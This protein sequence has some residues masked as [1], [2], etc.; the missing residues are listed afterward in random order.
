[1]KPFMD[2]Y[3]DKLCFDLQKFF[4]FEGADE[5]SENGLAYLNVHLKSNFSIELPPDFSRRLKFRNQK[6]ITRIHQHLYK[7]HGI[8]I[9][10]EFKTKLGNIVS[11]NAVKIP[12]V[13]GFTRDI[14]WDAGA[15]ADSGSCF[16]SDRWGTKN[17]IRDTGFAMLFYDQQDFDIAE[18][19]EA[20]IKKGLNY[21]QYRQSVPPKIGSGRAW[22]LPYRLAD[23]EEELG[24]AV[25]NAYH[26]N[27]N[28]THRYA[29]MVLAQH[30][31]LD[32]R[33]FRTV[34]NN[35]AYD[36]LYI[37]SE[38]STLVAPTENFAKVPN[39]PTQN[40][41]GIDFKYDLGDY[42]E[43]E[44]SYCECCNER[45]RLDDMT[46]IEGWGDVCEYCRDSDFFHCE[47]CCEYHHNDD[48]HTVYAKSTWS[49][50][51]IEELWCN[52]CFSEYAAE[53]DWC[54]DSYPMDFLYAIADTDRC[55]MC[56]DCYKTHGK[57]CTECLEYY[58]DESDNFDMERNMCSYC[59]ERERKE[60]EEPIN[61]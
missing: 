25:F 18:N 24:L 48:I 19:G 47:K 32:Y 12:V 49:G 7:T 50:H 14:F 59:I 15:F 51:T 30:L 45:F 61:G 57:T 34:N 21:R 2:R 22:V 6:I 13:F 28:V 56:G 52:E 27:G 58:D 38:R 9:H 46:Y 39:V 60:K 31:G 11:E 20:T 35:Y 5:I 41:Q 1:M 43:D 10:A 26:Y 4:Y 54:N 33:T 53:C 23:T 16:W 40:Y 42:T 8:K 17:F 29:A 3:A 55:R 36:D 37:N 44:R